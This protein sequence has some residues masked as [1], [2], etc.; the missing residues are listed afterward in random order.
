MS[1]IFST[2]GD[3]YLRSL[4]TDSRYYAGTFTISFWVRIETDTANVAPNVIFSVGNPSGQQ[5]QLR[6]NLN[7]EVQW[8]QAGDSIGNTFALVRD[9]WHNIVIAAP[10]GDE[11]TTYFDGTKDTVAT[12]LTS[13]TTATETFTVGANNDATPG[14]FSENFIF[15]SLGFWTQGNMSDVDVQSIYD[16]VNGGKDPTFIGDPV[17]YQ[18]FKMDNTEAVN[19][20]QHL[21]NEFS[22][23]ESARWRL[24]DGT[25]ASTAVDSSPLGLDIGY[26]T[27]TTTGVSGIVVGSEEYTSTG[28][29]ESA[30]ADDTE[31]GPWNFFT[32]LCWLN[33][34]TSGL[35]QKRIFSRA[36]DNNGNQ[37]SQDFM[38]GTLN[39]RLLRCRFTTE[40]PVVQT[41]A[42]T[43]GIAAETWHLAAF[44]YNRST[45]LVNIVVDGVVEETV[46][47]PSLGAALRSSADSNFLMTLF[48]GNDEGSP[49]NFASG[50]WSEIGLFDTDM[51]VDALNRL[52]MAGA[53]GLELDAGE[54]AACGSLGQIG[55]SS[56][57][58]VPLVS[59]TEPALSTPSFLV[60]VPFPVTTDI[61][62]PLVDRIPIEPFGAVALSVD[63]ATAQYVVSEFANIPSVDVTATEIFAV[64]TAAVEIPSV[65]VTFPR[66]FATGE[67]IFAISCGPNIGQVVP[68]LGSFRGDGEHVDSP[69]AIPGFE[70]GPTSHPNVGT[71]YVNPNPI[72]GTNDDLLYQTGRR[73]GAK[74]QLAYTFTVPASECHAVLHFSETGDG[75]NVG[76]GDRL[77]RFELE[78]VIRSN[79]ASVDVFGR[80][81]GVDTAVIAIGNFET[82]FPDETLNILITTISGEVTYTATINAIEIY[83]GQFPQQSDHQDGILVSL[84]TSAS[85][86]LLEGSTPFETVD[87]KVNVAEISADTDGLLVVGTG[88]TMPAQPQV[89]T[90]QNDG[91]GGNPNFNTGLM[92]GSFTIPTGARI[93]DPN[94]R[95]GI[96]AEC[97]GGI[98]RV[99]FSTGET[100]ITK[101]TN[102][103]AQTFNPTSGIWDFN[104]GIDTTV[105]EFGTDATHLIEATIF[106]F[107]GNPRTVSASFHFDL[108]DSEAAGFAEYWVD[109][110]NGND[111]ASGSFVTPFK[112]I[113]R[114]VDIEAGN[115]VDGMIV[116]VIGPNNRLEDESSVTAIA[117]GDNDDHHMIVRSDTVVGRAEITVT[118][119]GV[120]GRLI[121]FENLDFVGQQS[122]KKGDT[123]A[124]ETTRAWFEGCSL[125]SGGNLFNATDDFHLFKHTGSGIGD[126]G[127]DE[128]YVT[129]GSSVHDSAAISNDAMKLFLLGS[130]TY[131]KEF[132]FQNPPDGH[133]FSGI[134]VARLG[135]FDSDNPVNATWVSSPEPGHFVEYSDN[136]GGQTNDNAFIHG[137]RIISGDS[138][139]ISVRDDVGGGENIE[140]FAFAVLA[141]VAFNRT[142]SF[143]PNGIRSKDL[144]SL[145]FQHNTI[146]NQDFSIDAG[147]FQI[148]TNVEVQNNCIHRKFSITTDVVGDGVL[149]DNNHYHTNTGS[150]QPGT[151]ITI[152]PVNEDGLFLDFAAGDFRPDPDED[153]FG[154]NRAELAAKLEPVGAFM[155]EYSDTAPSLGAHEEKLLTSIELQPVDSALMFL[156]ISDVDALVRVDVNVPPDTLPSLNTT[157]TEIFA[158]L[159][160]SSDVN[161]VVVSMN[162]YFAVAQAGSPVIAPLDGKLTVTVNTSDVD[163]APIL[164]FANLR[165]A[166]NMGFFETPPE[167][168]CGLVE[169]GE[170]CVHNIWNQSFTRLGL[171]TVESQN[172]T[173]EFSNIMREIWPLTRQK[174]VVDH[175]WNSCVIE[176][177]FAALEGASDPPGDWGLWSELPACTLRILTVDGTPNRGGDVHWKVQRDKTTGKK[178]LL[179]RSTETPRVEYISDITDTHDLMAQ[180]AYALALVLAYEIAEKVG[181]SPEQIALLRVDMAEAISAAKASDGQEEYHQTHD[182]QTI[183][184]AMFTEG[185]RVIFD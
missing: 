94:V 140:A 177:E 8:F 37:G 93:T 172:E 20:N 95:I 33:I 101:A 17:A 116:N 55:T 24:Q 122:V 32:G 168:S 64:L 89:T 176:E 3:E 26:D 45:K 125:T 11:L 156:N 150:S 133:L 19:Y 124:G 137:N 180:T 109:W 21:T 170:I 28:G 112:T 51:S 27:S 52:Y 146:V 81:E 159:E 63:T 6:I 167:A 164:P 110:T 61:I 87:L 60:P 119:E 23:N 35:D 111:A 105:P 165:V 77:G 147:A 157:A 79:L 169:C 82:T 179:T 185:V 68:D 106:P 155:E 9:N 182:D 15:A 181:T 2:D 80:G 39:G 138:S 44:T 75:G 173:D 175:S 143:G 96:K 54:D 12:G 148:F 10:Q 18:H 98:Q 13:R 135:E 84:N 103:G 43:T 183:L 74:T 141:N 67:R 102:V 158:F 58:F 50:N 59:T 34:G 100:D 16:G 114:A 151:N 22:S 113:W 166:V 115:P 25:S 160:A 136:S 153:L 130:I 42:M 70:V 144:N 126:L 48:A 14:N 65:A 117:V 30:T 91:T 145:V 46:T 132:C 29:T 36:Q 134:T 53:R 83:V 47:N 129:G 108:D 66:M 41:L 71:T 38:F 178:A 118:G 120:R 5:L 131:V 142:F 4:A 88:G 62:V 1:R 128:I 72:S 152:S 86:G 90:G 40:T 78:S 69:G 154:I 99:A 174:F 163:I 127:W 49:A 121:K 56:W 31:I 161:I 184:D 107:N 73:A 171:P 104:V 97:P 149:V 139:L 57:N 76:K 85:D 7:D 92:A 123:G 162:D